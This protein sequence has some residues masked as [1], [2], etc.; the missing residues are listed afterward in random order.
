[1]S[2]KEQILQVLSRAL[3]TFGSLSTLTQN[4]T[5]QY[6]IKEQ[7]RDLNKAIAHV[8]ETPKTE[9]VEFD[10]LKKSG[11]V[12]V[13]REAL[14]QNVRAF[15]D[16]TTG[17][18]KYLLTE[19]DSDLLYEDVMIIPNLKNA[20]TVSGGQQNDESCKPKNMISGD[21]LSGRPITC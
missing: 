18:I 1:M 6:I 20:A 19:N 16:V 15:R 3:S 12:D 13:M 5:A 8:K 2:Q 11:N 17:E 9:H 21:I 14:R 7:I 10:R 4:T